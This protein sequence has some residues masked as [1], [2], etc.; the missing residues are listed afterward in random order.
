MRRIVRAAIAAVGAT[1]LLLLAACDLDGNDEVTLTLVNELSPDVET[2]EATTI[3]IAGSSTTLV[4]DEDTPVAESDIVL[5]DAGQHD[6]EIEVTAELADGEQLLC[7]FDQELYLE[8]DA[9][10]TV[11]WQYDPATGECVDAQLIRTR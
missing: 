4:V 11:T 5:P 7:N 6:Y 10:F 1:G 8:G 9:E 3:T 2:E